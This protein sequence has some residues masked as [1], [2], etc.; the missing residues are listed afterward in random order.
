MENR[1]IGKIVT[2]KPIITAFGLSNQNVLRNE[3]IKKVID[4][5]KTCESVDQYVYPAT[6][7]QI[8]END[9]NLS[10][11]CYLDTFMNE[12]RSRTTETHGLLIHDP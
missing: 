12:Q 8:Q 11:P 1:P 9:Y 10:I 2:D 7:A 3:K 6:L 4:T 5:Y